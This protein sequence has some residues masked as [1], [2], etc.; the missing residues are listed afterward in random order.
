MDCDLDVYLNEPVQLSITSSS[1]TLSSW[2]GIA[3]LTRV[4]E[5]QHGG[6]AALAA[7]VSMLRRRR[8]R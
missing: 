6:I 1:G 4:P 7:L 2:S 3:G 5:A 8:A